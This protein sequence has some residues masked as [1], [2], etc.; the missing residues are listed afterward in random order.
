MKRVKMFIMNCCHFRQMQSKGQ[1][2]VWKD[3][4]MSNRKCYAEKATR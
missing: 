2:S 3:C 4:K 1:K